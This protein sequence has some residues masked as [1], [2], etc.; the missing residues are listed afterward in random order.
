MLAGVHQS[1]L[2]AKSGIEAVGAVTCKI[3]SFTA[4]QVAAILAGA[5]GTTSHIWVVIATGQFTVAGVAKVTGE[6]SLHASV[7]FFVGDHHPFTILHTQVYSSTLPSPLA[8][9]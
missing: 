2:Q 7:V 4:D 1:I 9:V 8:G 3:H 6:P 5:P